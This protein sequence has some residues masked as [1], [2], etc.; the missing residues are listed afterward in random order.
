MLKVPLAL[1]GML[2]GLTHGRISRAKAA[3]E[4]TLLIDLA[5]AFFVSSDWDI[6][7]YQQ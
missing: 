2:L 5:L 7:C 4:E 3:P 1:E 6:D